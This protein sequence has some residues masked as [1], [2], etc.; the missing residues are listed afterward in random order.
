[1]PTHLKP[2]FIE[3]EKSHVLLVRQ[4]YFLHEPSPLIFKT[5]NFS[6]AC[7]ICFLC[8]K[9]KVANLSKWPMCNISF[10]F[11]NEEGL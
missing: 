4:N 2:P 6:N 11:Y 3:R 10:L 5:V 8:G 9:K 7:D 1:M